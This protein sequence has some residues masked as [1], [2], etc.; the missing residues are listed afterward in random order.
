MAGWQGQVGAD[1]HIAVTALSIGRWCRL[2]DCRLG[3]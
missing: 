1:L 2:E 3:S